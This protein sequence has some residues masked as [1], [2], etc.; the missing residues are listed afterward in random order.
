MYNDLYF[1]QTTKAAQLSQVQQ[2]STASPL[3]V[4]STA[5]S[6]LAQKQP[7]TPQTPAT[8]AEA[9]PLLREESNSD[10]QIVDEHGQPVDWQN[11]P[12]EPRYCVCNQVSYGDMV[13][14]DNDDVSDT[15]RIM[16][17]MKTDIIAIQIGQAVIL[18]IIYVIHNWRFRSATS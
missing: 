15:Y 3:L 16:A 4:S 12:N 10:L 5:A 8:P 13:G 7:L 6:L 1:R 18:V 14:C 11:D 9:S 2:Q 17:D